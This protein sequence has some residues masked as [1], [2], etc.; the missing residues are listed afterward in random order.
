MQEESAGGKVDVMWFKEE[1]KS[2]ITLYKNKTSSMI[3]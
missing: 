3:I 1:S 2:C